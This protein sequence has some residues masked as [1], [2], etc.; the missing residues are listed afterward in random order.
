MENASLFPMDSPDSRALASLFRLVTCSCI[1]F[2]SSRFASKVS[3]SLGVEYPVSTMWD[4]PKGRRN[5]TDFLTGSF[6]I[7]SGTNSETRNVSAEIRNASCRDILPSEVRAGS[8][9]LKGNPKPHFPMMRRVSYSDSVRWGWRMTCL[10][11]LTLNAKDCTE[12]TPL[13][14]FDDHPSSDTISR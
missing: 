8:D 10:S 1:N 6:C 3:L 9:Q 12:G 2:S 14:S 4:T 13:R 11:Q 5:W 7:C